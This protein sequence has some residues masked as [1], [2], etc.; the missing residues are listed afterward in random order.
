MKLLLSFIFLTS[1]LFGANPK[2]YA[3]LGDSIYNNA[4]KIE[5]L[6]KIKQYDSFSERISRYVREV[7]MLKVE[8]YALEAKKSNKNKQYLQ[9]L[10]EL[11]KTNDFFVRNAQAM[12]RKSMK[13]KNYTLFAQLLDTGLIDLERNKKEILSFYNKHQD[14]VPLFGKLQEL[15]MQN[16]LKRGSKHTKEYYEKLRK[17][18]EQEKIRRLRERDKQRQEALQRRLEKEVKEKKEKIRE[19]Q[20]SELKKDI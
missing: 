6:K 15:V 9:K 13:Q 16:K 18:K 10:R 8:G 11:A 3:S 5:K 12:Y 19:E 17:M 7:D 20:I 1:L 14:E 2:V 4:P